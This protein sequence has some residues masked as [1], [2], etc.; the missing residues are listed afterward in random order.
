[1]IDVMLDSGHVVT[2]CLAFVLGVAVSVLV[3][4]EW[5]RR[6]RLPTHLEVERLTNAL[7][8][9]QI[10]LQN[11]QKTAEAL[12]DE[13]TGWRQRR[14]ALYGGRS[15]APGLILEAPL[16]RVEGIEEIKLGGDA[17]RPSKPSTPSGFAD[18][19]TLAS[20]SG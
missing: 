16:S 14:S 8:T 11:T 1:M 5:I 10:Q 7:R 20:Y 13:V 18:T 2:M 4:L 6:D 19:Q 12:R 15:S 3:G 17:N 9:T